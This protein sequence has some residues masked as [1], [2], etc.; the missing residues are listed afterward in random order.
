MENKLLFGIYVFLGFYILYKTYE[1]LKKPA[2][3]RDEVD[4][5]LNS[6]KYRVKGRFEE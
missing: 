1:L 2:S 3:Y 6:E 5:I 4:K